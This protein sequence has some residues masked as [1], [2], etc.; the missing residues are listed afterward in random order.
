M[1]LQAVIGAAGIGAAGRYRGQTHGFWEVL[2]KVHIYDLVVLATLPSIVEPDIL[3][4]LR[5]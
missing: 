3:H 5:N 4:R 1:V 2:M